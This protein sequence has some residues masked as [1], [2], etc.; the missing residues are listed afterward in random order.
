MPKVF[1]KSAERAIL[2][3]FKG[4]DGRPQTITIGP[5]R[6][7]DV[8]EEHRAAI[9]KGLTERQQS[10]LVWGDGDIDVARASHQVLLNRE[11][12]RA[13]ALAA[14]NAALR[15]QIEALEKLVAAGKPRA[16]RAA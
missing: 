7:T 16:A 4:P 13:D 11:K 9:L 1:N 12:A 6:V 14:E 15:G 3:T 2:H 5:N 10:D 8:P